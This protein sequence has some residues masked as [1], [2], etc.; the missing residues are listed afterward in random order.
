[1]VIHACDLSKRVVDTG[2]WNEAS[3]GFLERPFLRTATNISKMVYWVKAHAHQ[4][5]QP[6]F[7][8][9]EPHGRRH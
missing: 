1:M 6:E 8:L 2:E 5:W 4:V 7:G 3:L 9:Q